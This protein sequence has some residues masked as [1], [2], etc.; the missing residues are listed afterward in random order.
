MSKT[1]ETEGR[2]KCGNKYRKLFVT[3]SL[4]PSVARGVTDGRAN[5]LLDA[6][7]NKG[8]TNA[9]TRMASVSAFV[10]AKAEGVGLLATFSLSCG[11]VVQR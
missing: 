11:V 2:E 9:L 1:N 8:T 4:P 7:R 10:W 3:S 5:I 6:S